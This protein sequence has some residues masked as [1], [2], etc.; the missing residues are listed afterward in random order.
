MKLFLLNYKYSA[1]KYIFIIKKQANQE[2]NMQKTE[3]FA[4]QAHKGTDNHG[5]WLLSTGARK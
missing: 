4:D 5:A 1:V 3:K 2:K